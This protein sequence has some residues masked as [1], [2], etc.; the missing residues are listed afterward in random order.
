M[1]GVCALQC[2]VVIRLFS[3]E[4]Y[5]ASPSVYVE[6]PPND[7]Q[8]IQFSRFAGACFPTVTARLP[9]RH[10]ILPFRRRVLKFLPTPILYAEKAI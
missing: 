4:R 9:S 1:Y 10:I 3:L 2:A 6:C 5:Y 8:G 7:V